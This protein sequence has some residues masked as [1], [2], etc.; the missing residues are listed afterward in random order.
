VEESVSEIRFFDRLSL[1]ELHNAAFGEIVFRIKM[2]IKT[3]YENS[4]NELIAASFTAW[5]MLAA[6][7]SEITWQQ[8]IKMLGLSDSKSID[9]ETKKQIAKKSYAIAD[10][11]ARSGGK[12]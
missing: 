8:Y 12:K 11:I 10:M 3:K 5:Q 1:A 6:Q 7:G 9:A 2:L 4:K